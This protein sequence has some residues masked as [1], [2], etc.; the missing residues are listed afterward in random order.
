MMVMK[1]KKA[2]EDLKLNWIS[3]PCWDIEKTKGFEENEKELLE[4]RLMVERN[5]ERKEVEKRVYALCEKYG[6]N[7]EL[8]KIRKTKEHSPK[9]MF[10]MW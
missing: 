3:D 6:C 2:I 5:N 4:Y 1:T 8:L 10:R 9:T 7:A